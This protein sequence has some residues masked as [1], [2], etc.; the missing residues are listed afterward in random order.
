VLCCTLLHAGDDTVTPFRLISH[1]LIRSEFST[2]SLLFSLLKN[3][4]GSKETLIRS[5]PGFML[6]R[7]SGGRGGADP[8]PRFMLKR[9]SGGRGGADPKPNYYQ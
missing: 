8:K 9:G 1:S 7:G 2:T 4:S 5:K 6:K 3:L